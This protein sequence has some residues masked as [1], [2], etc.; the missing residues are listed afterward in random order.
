MTRAAGKKNNGEEAFAA[1]PGRLPQ[2]AEGDTAG[3]RGADHQAAPG[4]DPGKGL[5]APHA[6]RSF[7]AW[8]AAESTCQ[9]VLH[10]R[11]S[12]FQRQF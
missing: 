2:P 10:A 4:T 1:R 7:S 8:E 12:A 9:R 5:D 6:I 11:R 3:H